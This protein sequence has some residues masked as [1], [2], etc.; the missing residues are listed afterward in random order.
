MKKLKQN[1]RSITSLK[2]NFKLRKVS[3]YLH[4]LSNFLFIIIKTV[5][6]WVRIAERSMLLIRQTLNCGFSLQ[7]HIHTSLST[8]TL[9]TLITLQRYRHSALNPWVWVCARVQAP[10]PPV[11]WGSSDG[12]H[13]V[14][15]CVSAARSCTTLQR[16]EREPVNTTSLIFINSDV[17]V[18]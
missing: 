12:R 11:S 17:A 8:L 2:C 4:R 15:W 18:R 13:S 9:L 16:S 3:S 5:I 10:F 1:I 6:S 7:S 14:R